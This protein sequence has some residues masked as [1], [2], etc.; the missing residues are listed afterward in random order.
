MNWGHFLGNPFGHGPY[1]QPAVRENPSQDAWGRKYMKVDNMDPPDK[2]GRHPK[3]K[4]L[5][6]F[7]IEPH[8][9][10][11][12]LTAPKHKGDALISEDDARSMFGKDF[13]DGFGYLSDEYLEVL[14]KL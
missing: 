5:V 6:M 12:I 7:E 11:Y 14:E 4:H 8:Y 3:Y 13:D 2:R 9:G 1:G 10:S